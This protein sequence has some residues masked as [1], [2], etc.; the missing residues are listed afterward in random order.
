MTKTCAGPCQQTLPV[1]DFA[2]AHDRR[3][4]RYPYCRPCRR[5]LD[6]RARKKRALGRTDWT[7]AEPIRAH[8][9]QLLIRGM[10]RHQI[11][12]LAGVNRTSIRNLVIGQP[13]A[14]QP[15]A[16]RL[17]K[18]TAAKLLAVT[19]APC[20]P[21]PVADHLAR[22]AGATIDN[23]GT[24]RRLEALMAN[25]WSARE[26]ARRLGHTHP[27][28]QLPRHRRVT[29]STAQAVRTLYDELANTP[30]PSQRAA[31]L[32]RGRGYLPPG[33]W[34]DDTIDDPDATPAGLAWEV[35]PGATIH[36]DADRD[37]QVAILTRAGHGPTEIARQLGVSRQ[38]VARAVARNQAAGPLKRI[39]RS[40]A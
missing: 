22:Q 3:D 6:M 30:G 13:H 10:T 24:R 16:T 33:W 31:T 18:D 38:T 28:L 4:G 23:T 9:E 5:L 19:Y 25:G 39:R 7:D 29:S 17:R 35:Q 34:D 32:Y 1:D 11:A 27:G 37:E 14:N 8:I 36:L 20:Q 26:L 2:I 21:A 12:E 15:P 40:A